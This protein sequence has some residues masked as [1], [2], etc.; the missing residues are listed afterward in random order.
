MASVKVGSASGSSSTN[1]NAS[2]KN[3]L[4]ATAPDTLLTSVGGNMTTHRA[5]LATL[6]AHV[7]Q[8]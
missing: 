5:T 7:Q 4:T 8:S 2:N 6:A 3:A 1:K